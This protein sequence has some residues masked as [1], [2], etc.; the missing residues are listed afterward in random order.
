M[1]FLKSFLPKFLYNGDQDQNPESNEE[2]EDEKNS[3]ENREEP[4]KIDQNNKL[5][6]TVFQRNVSHQNYIP[7]EKN[8]SNVIDQGNHGVQLF[9]QKKY[10]ESKEI[11]MKVCED[12]ITL[13]KQ[14]QNIAV[15]EY[16][17]KFLKY[18]EE[19][20]KNLKVFLLF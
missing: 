14:H 9:N 2:V 20:H 5:T 15:K 18:S 16:L 6:K 7:Y 11:L 13:Y 8:L 12:L 10:K 1:N 3:N 17:M 4:K 19:C